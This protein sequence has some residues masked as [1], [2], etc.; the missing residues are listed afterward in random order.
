MSH[1]LESALN[2]DI[3]DLVPDSAAAWL[4]LA[5]LLVELVQTSRDALFNF[6]LSGDTTVTTEISPFSWADVSHLQKSLVYDFD[7]DARW[8][9]ATNWNGQIAI[10][11]I[12]VLV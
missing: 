9:Q 4:A 8:H 3:P 12:N 2:Y 7:D 1:E 6:Q 10:P 5:I 11:H